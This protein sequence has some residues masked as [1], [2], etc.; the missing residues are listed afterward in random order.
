M[1]SGCIP[2]GC[3]PGNWPMACGCGTW[4]VGGGAAKLAGGWYTYREIPT[5]I[6]TYTQ[7]VSGSHCGLTCCC[8]RDC[9]GSC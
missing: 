2:S 6:V 1:V 4:S 9:I 5:F 3:C 8:G 7:G